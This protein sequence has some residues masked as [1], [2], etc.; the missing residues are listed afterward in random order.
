MT[1]AEH[2]EGVCMYATVRILKVLLESDFLKEWVSSSALLLLE[3]P[4]EKPAIAGSPRNPPFP[5]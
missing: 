2:T 1:V 3:A 5:E 4:C